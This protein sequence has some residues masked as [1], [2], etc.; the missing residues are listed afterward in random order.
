MYKHKMLLLVVTAVIS[1]IPVLLSG[2]WLETTLTVTGTPTTMCWNATNNKVY[3][4]DNFGRYLRIIDGATNSII[5]SLQ[6]GYNTGALCWN[7]TNNKIYCAHEGAST[8]YVSVING[9]TDAKICSIPCGT[10]KY[11]VWNSQNNKVYAAHW[12]S[13]MM[14]V[15]DGVANNVIKTTAIGVEIYAIC[16][17]STNNKVYTANYYN[18]NVSIVSCATDTLVATVSTPY[19]PIALCYNSTNNKVYVAC[20]NSNNVMVLNGATNAVVK[21]ISLGLSASPR[22]LCWNSTNNRVYCALEGTNKVAVIN[23]TNDSLI[24]TISV[25]SYPQTVLWNQINNKVYVGNQQSNNVSIINC[26]TNTVISTT[27]VGTYPAVLCYNATN[28]RTYIGNRNSGTLSVF[29][30]SMASGVEEYSPLSAI[31]NSL[32]VFPNPARTFFAIKSPVNINS[33]KIFDISGNLIKQ[34][35]LRN[36]RV[37]LDGIKNGVYFIKINDEI[38]KEKLVVTR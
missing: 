23:C 16:W 33:V 22:S 26:A 1:F 38:V 4:N 6:L 19:K 17:N 34:E 3:C 10:I 13:G 18:D 20:Y 8:P 25:G 2:Q 15:I 12:N 37:S 28:N 30:E 27:T 5:T 31:H 35:K 7:S 36:K 9:A 32:E 14:S 21:T 11:M 29:R 24:T